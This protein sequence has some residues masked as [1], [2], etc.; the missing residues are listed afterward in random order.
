[1]A[2]NDEVG[3]TRVVLEVRW[4]VED[5]VMILRNGYDG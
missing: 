5:M 3:R 4:G 2:H 1:M